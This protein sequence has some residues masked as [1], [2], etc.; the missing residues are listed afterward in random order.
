MAAI[1]EGIN[2]FMERSQVLI[3]A[4]DEVGKLHPFIAGAA[5]SIIRDQ[6]AQLNKTLTSGCY[7]VQ[8]E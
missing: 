2:H 1:E 5:R 4:L 8:S 3:N 6:W 7:G